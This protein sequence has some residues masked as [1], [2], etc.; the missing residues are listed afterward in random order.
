PPGG[1]GRFC[2]GPGQKRLMSKKRGPPPKGGG[3]GGGAPRGGG[4][5]ARQYDHVGVAHRV[6]GGG[7]DAHADALSRRFQGDTV[8]FRK[9]NIP[10]GNVIDAAVAE[11]GS[12]R[13]AGL[14]KADEGNA[15]GVAAGLEPTCVCQPVV[16]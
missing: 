10:G 2:C 9:Q 8:A 15:R 11:A 1:G 16:D 4:G 6:G 3:A 12:D 14:A 5:G 7:R 13:L